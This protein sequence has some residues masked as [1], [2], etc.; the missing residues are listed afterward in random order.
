M[1]GPW[2]SAGAAGRRKVSGWLVGDRRF[3]VGEHRPQDVEP[4]RMPT[5]RPSRVTG[6]RW[7]DASRSVASAALSDADSSMVVGGVDITELHRLGRQMTLVFGGRRREFP[8]EHVDHSL[9][10]GEQVAL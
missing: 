9:L 7:S 3:D 4:V 8:G 5:R 1:V 10:P 6:R 2:P